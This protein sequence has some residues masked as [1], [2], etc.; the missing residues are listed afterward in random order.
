RRVEHHGRG[1][2][3]VRHRER[4]RDRAPD[5]APD[6][7]RPSYPQVVKQ[8]HALGD[9]IPPTE[10]LYPPPG[11]ARLA[12]VEGDAREVLAQRGEPVEPPVDAVC[13]P[14]LHGRGEPARREHQQCRPRPGHLV[15]RPDPVDLHEGH[16]YS[17]TWIPPRTWP[18]E[19]TSAT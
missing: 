7:R 9:V 1:P 16:L 14:P 17:G 11:P 4:G 3:R 8:P 5:A 13:R 18:P 15:P 2:R 12:L 6:Q 10:P 19:R